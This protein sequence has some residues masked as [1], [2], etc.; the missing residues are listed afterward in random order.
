MEFYYFSYGINMAKRVIEARGLNFKF[1]SLGILRD[2]R[3]AFHRYSSEW[4]GLT[5]NLE[6]K[7]G[8]EAYG[9]IFLTDEQDLEK[10]DIFEGVD[11]GE[12]D[13]TQVQVHPSNS[14]ILDEP[15]TCYTYIRNSPDPDVGNFS[16]NYLTI[17]LE[18][19]KEYGFPKHLIRIIEDRLDRTFI[20]DRTRKRR[21]AST[22]GKYLIQIDKTSLDKLDLKEGQDIV[23]G[24]K[25][26]Y[27]PARIQG[28]EGEE[29]QK[30]CRLDK[31]IRNVLGLEEM[32]L[33]RATVTIYPVKF[34]TVDEKTGWDRAIQVI[35]LIVSIVFFIWMPYLLI[36]KRIYPRTFLLKVQR[37]KSD[38]VEKNVAIVPKQYLKLIG[39]EEGK[40]IDI[41]VPVYADDLFVLRRLTIRAFSD[42]NIEKEEQMKSQRIYLDGTTRDLLGLPYTIPDEEF[43]FAE[44]TPNLNALL[45]ERGILYLATILFLIGRFQ[46]LLINFG[47][48]N[49]LLDFWISVVLSIWFIGIVVYFEMKNKIRY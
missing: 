14:K 25:K 5:A 42:E 23:V 8:S 16:L 33:Q 22:K 27:A 17:L 6:V 19:Y 32:T 26:Q 9:V 31:S 4:N 34:E 13:R 47:R 39:L 7:R 21:R 29:N 46:T 36:K 44:I 43:P 18:S 24:Y 45:A 28:L 10:L 1:V 41:E 20:V 38:I 40:F 11:R 15:I 35:S 37:L 3:I 49:A 30:I 48:P 2:H 12:A